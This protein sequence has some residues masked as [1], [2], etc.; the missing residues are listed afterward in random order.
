MEQPT[1]KPD[2]K[3][4]ATD[5]S[6]APNG[7]SNNTEALEKVS[8]GSDSQPSSEILTERA[9]ST[10][11]MKK[12]VHWSPD[13]VTEPTF[14]SSPKE[15]PSNPEI[16]SS[17]SY[18]DSS[19]SY[20]DSSSPY[21][22]SSSPS[23]DSSSPSSDSSSSVTEKVDV[24]KNVLGRWG[25][26]LGEATRK[27]ETL[28]GN[29]WQH[30]KTNPSF[31]EAALGRIV[32]GTKVL[33]EGGYDRLFLRTFDTV[34][35]EHLQNYFACYLSTSAGPVMGVVYI[36]SAKL[37]YCSD[38]PLSYKSDNQREWSFY[39][40]VIPLYQLKAVNPSSNN[41][42]PAEKYIQLISADNQEF[43]F[44]GFLN[45]ESAVE[46]LQ[47]AFEANKLQSQ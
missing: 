7:D 35:G 12:S 14:D 1:P 9:A 36:S 27:A 26:K 28:A 23:S 30:L 3:P 10:R 44:M 38:N 37:A 18:S 22:D 33:A 31:A 11:N 25:R 6:H 39:K 17:L 16:H 32:Q 29:T 41:A 34:A 2:H 47:K 15:S 4:N 5:S 40:I 20:S 42:N 24:V 45:Y 43:W 13:L 19:L 21:S 46:C 8:P